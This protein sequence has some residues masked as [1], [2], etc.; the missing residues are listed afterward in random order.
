MTSLQMHQVFLKINSISLFMC[1]LSEYIFIV[2]FDLAING[3]IISLAIKYSIEISYQTFY[4]WKYSE[5]EF[6]RCPSFAKF[7]EGL[8]ETFTFTIFVLV[9]STAEICCFEMVSVILFRTAN[10]KRNIAIWS[11]LYQL[12]VNSKW[13]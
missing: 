11:S 1:L 10:P 9:S 13:S 3:L 5:A 2:Y 12:I 7:K 6:F 8:W 4:I